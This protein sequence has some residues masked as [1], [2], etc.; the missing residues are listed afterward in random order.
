M[1]LQVSMS[2]ST[3]AQFSAPPSEPAKSTFLSV[4]R[5]HPFILPMSV[6]NWKSTTDGIHIAAARF[7]FVGLSSVQLA[8]SFKYKGRPAS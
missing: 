8:H 2:E 6:R 3:T 7:W 1:S 4:E 5:H